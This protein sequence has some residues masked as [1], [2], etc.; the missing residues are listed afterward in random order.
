MLKYD[1]N[2][3]IG[4]IT[5]VYHWIDYKYESSLRVIYYEMLK[6][7]NHIQVILGK[8]KE[9]MALTS[10]ASECFLCVCFFFFFRKTKSCLFPPKLSL[11]SA[12]SV[13]EFQ[14]HA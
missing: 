1:L 8:N 9:R 2:K 13:L 5:V 14:E 3:Y 6:E 10:I 11:T 4:N 7:F 12:D